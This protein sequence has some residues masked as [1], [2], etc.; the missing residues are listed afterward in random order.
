MNVVFDA[1]KVTIVMSILFMILLAFRVNSIMKRYK[2]NKTSLPEQI[3]GWILALAICIIPVI[4]VF[5]TFY[6]GI[7][8]SEEDLEKIIARDHKRKGEE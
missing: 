3:R 4:N 7:F 8:T 2:S 5:F 6:A 1:Y